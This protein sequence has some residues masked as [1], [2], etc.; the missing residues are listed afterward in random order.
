MRQEIGGREEGERSEER[1]A[2]SERGAGRRRKV[3]GEAIRRD[4]EGRGSE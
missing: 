3:E 1:V 2:V 4:N